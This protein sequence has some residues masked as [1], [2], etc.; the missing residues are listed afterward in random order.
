MCFCILQI[1][2][3]GTQRNGENASCCCAVPPPGRRWDARNRAEPRTPARAPRRRPSAEKRTITRGVKPNILWGRACSLLLPAPPRRDLLRHRTFSPCGRRLLRTRVPTRKDTGSGRRDQ[4]TRPALGPKDGQRAR[5]A[6]HPRGAVEGPACGVCDGVSAELELRGGTPARAGR[7][8]KTLALA[9]GLGP[10]QLSPEEERRQGSARQASR[11][12]KRR[13]C[14][15]NARS[16]TR[17]DIPCCGRRGS[18]NWYLLLRGVRFPTLHTRETEKR[19]F[20]PQKERAAR[21][22]RS[23]RALPAPRG[24]APAHRRSASARRGARRCAAAP[25]S[26]QGRELTGGEEGGRRG[27]RLLGPGL[28]ETARLRP[29]GTSARGFRPLPHHDQPRATRRAGPTEESRGKDGGVVTR[30]AAPGRSPEPGGPG[31]LPVGPRGRADASRRQTQRLE[32]AP[33]QL[34]QPAASR[35]HGDPAARRR[36]SGGRGEERAARRHAHSTPPRVRRGGAKGNTTSPSAPEA[37]L[38][39]SRAVLLRT[40]HGLM[41]RTPPGKR[42]SEFWPLTLGT[43]TASPLPTCWLW[44]SLCSATSFAHEEQ[45]SRNQTEDFPV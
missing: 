15:G 23:A 24:T 32:A 12:W 19:A 43:A 27:G 40:S 4:R 41:L 39:T 22:T 17:P 33:V 2:R 7:L 42:A 18:E 5:G 34:Q 16:P 30:P 3:A 25:R 37:V 13:G 38:E 10:P 8:P 28:A 14:P 20:R 1:I 11:G 36:R 44:G 21:R 35:R 31:S 45:Q 29:E 9:L 26:P 6:G